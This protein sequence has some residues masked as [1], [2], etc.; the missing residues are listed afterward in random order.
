MDKPKSNCCYYAGHVQDNEAVNQQGVS[1]ADWPHLLIN[2]HTL[3]AL[4][5]FTKGQGGVGLTLKKG[6]K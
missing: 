6:K 2:N 1:I 4:N 5:K 3:R